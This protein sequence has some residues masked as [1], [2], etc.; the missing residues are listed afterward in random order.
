[1]NIDLE[2]AL[3]DNAVH[4]ACAL[5]FAAV[6]RYFER[7]EGRAY[8]R[9]WIWS[10]LAFAAYSVGAVAGR[11]LAPGLPPSSLARF[12]VSVVSLAA[13]YLQVA[14][15]LLGA[16]E[17]T[18]RTRL[19]GAWE[20]PTIVL[21]L[22]IGVVL[23]MLWIDD[24]SA[25]ARRY[26]VRV[27][28]RAIV[29]CAAFM[30][31][32]VWTAMERGP[33]RGL[34]SSL[35]PSALFLY[36]VDQ[37]ALYVFALPINQSS[38]TPMA[39]L[40]PGFG[41]FDVFIQLLIGLGMLLWML[42]QARE[43]RR[44]DWRRLAESEERYRTLVES[45][46]DGILT[47]DTLG[48]VLFANSTAAAMFGYERHELA[49]MRLD[50]LV[51]GEQAR[52][53]VSGDEGWA[54]QAP[55]T[56]LNVTAHHRSGR[57]FAVEVSLTEH[58]NGRE[59]RVTGI[60]RDVSERYRMEAQLL[61]AQKMEAVGRLTG[62]IAHDFN[63]LLTA[64]GG[65]AEMSLPQLEPGDPL[66]SRILD[67]RRAAER[68]SNLTRK[69]LAFS[70]NQPMEARA[71]DVNRVL[72]DLGPLLKRLIGEDVTITLTAASGPLPIWADAGQI[73]QV[74]INL[75]VNA[76]DAMPDGGR[77][78]ITAERVELD[79]TAVARQ[80]RARAGTFARVSVADTGTGI[81]ARDLPH[82][83]EPFFTTKEADRGTGLGLAISYGVIEQ[84]G[85]WIDVDSEPAR[86]TVF[87]V[88]L[89]LAAV[90]DAAAE[91]T[92]ATP[93]MPRGRET[94]LIVE[95]EE[96]VRLIL[97]EAL[98]NAGY[99]VLEAGTGP[100]A[101]AEWDQHAAS[102]D[103]LLCDVVMPDGI[104]GSD[105]ARRLTDARPDLHVILM[106]GYQ[107]HATDLP[108]AMFLAKPFSLQRLLVAV[109]QCLD[110]STAEVRN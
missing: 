9:Y 38:A 84:H 44:A 110:A 71:L 99:T 63:N 33:R 94:V 8:L 42:E 15:L 18:R 54:R 28:V 106:S 79:G 41:Y 29:V 73:D 3:L 13:A 70:R 105:L 4:V 51:P 103:L 11:I 101:L 90:I 48:F 107:E 46:P 52:V 57:R 39:A 37:A 80:P 24:P 56:A 67:I 21:S 19:K 86:G 26:F 27:G 17:F 30:A 83:F 81:A 36:G 92:V 43:E 55:W 7:Q 69:L 40:R 77:L 23:T 109:R 25:G 16:Y 95:D 68:A 58:M 108:G 53:L 76:R 47:V 14:W 96:P 64:I 34:A 20:V 65:Y 59:R 6:L 87:S 45:A 66:H 50:V 74:L 78:T 2:M 32:A 61:Q 85:G 100:A 98:S 35:L 31:A 10:W 82:I 75:A 89:P 1:M 72:A 12:I 60:V 22:G 49:G 104:S 97:G 102:I 88:F 93:V 5:V 91:T 62:G